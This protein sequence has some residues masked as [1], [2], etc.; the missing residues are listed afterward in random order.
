MFIYF[1]KGDISEIDWKLIPSN[2]AVSS[3]Q[4]ILTTC[5]NAS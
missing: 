4:K 2:I 1:D 3:S 5:V